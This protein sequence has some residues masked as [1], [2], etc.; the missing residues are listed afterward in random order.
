M[1]SCF[2]FGTDFQKETINS[3]FLKQVMYLL[4]N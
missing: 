2:Y 3:W 4:K 1:V